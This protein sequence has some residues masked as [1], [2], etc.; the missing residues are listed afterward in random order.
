[1]EL[2]VE[3]S[4]LI[5][6]RAV[7]ITRASIL[8]LQETLRKPSILPALRRNVQS[9]LEARGMR[10]DPP[11]N[12][13]RN[14]IRF[15]GDKDSS[16]SSYC[17]KCGFTRVTQEISKQTDFDENGWFYPV[18]LTCTHP[19]CHHTWTEKFTLTKPSVR[20]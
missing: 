16:Y 20:L 7:H 10:K 9:E 19:N 18:K 17:P 15:N 6:G 12:P 11:K 1:V 4:L 13:Q 2:T 8:D 3:N 14:I 5:H